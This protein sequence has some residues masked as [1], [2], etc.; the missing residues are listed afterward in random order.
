VVWI[1]IGQRTPPG[2]PPLGTISPAALHQLQE[3]FN[4]DADD[5]AR[6]ILLLSPT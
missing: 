5:R 1:A 3:A 6:V 4:R 2:Q